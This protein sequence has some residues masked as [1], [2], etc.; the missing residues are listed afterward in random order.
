MVPTKGRLQLEVVDLF[1][2]LIVEFTHVTASLLTQS[3]GSVFDL[4]RENKE[5]S[6]Y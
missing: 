4:V 2:A 3:A 1:S 6:V 5:Y